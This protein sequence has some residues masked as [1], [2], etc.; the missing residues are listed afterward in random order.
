MKRIPILWAKSHKQ[1]CLENF[2]QE[3]VGMTVRGGLQVVQSGENGLADP[4]G[5][6]ILFFLS[7]RGMRRLSGAVVLRKS[8]L[9]GYSWSRVE[10]QNER[11]MGFYNEKGSPQAIYRLRWAGGD[12]EIRT[13]ARC[14]DAYRISSADPS[15]TWVHL[16][17]DTMP[18]LVLWHTFSF[19]ARACLQITLKVS[20]AGMKEQKIA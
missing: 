4:Q 14:L 15:T 10:W 16:Q 2:W 7:I 3:R 13:L 8:L 1:I 5:Q 9:W 12:G 20:V 17:N 19:D 18:W 11:M 6:P